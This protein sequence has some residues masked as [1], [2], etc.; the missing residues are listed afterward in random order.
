M[1]TYFI[2]LVTIIIFSNIHNLLVDHCEDYKNSPN[3]TYPGMGNKYPSEWMIWKG[4]KSVFDFTL[5]FNELI[6]TLNKGQTK[7]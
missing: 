1:K 7:I 2:L 3:A 6:I 4:V 5:I